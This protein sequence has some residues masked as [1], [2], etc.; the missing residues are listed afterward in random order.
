MTDADHQP[1]CLDQMI[2]TVISD[3]ENH[4]CT[5]VTLNNFFFGQTWNIFDLMGWEWEVADGCCC[6]SQQALE[7]G[8]P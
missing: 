1:G 2:K 8:T 5:L 7:E 3:A 6:F 4:L